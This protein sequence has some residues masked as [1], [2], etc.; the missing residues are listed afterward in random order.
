MRNTTS[1]GTCFM[2]YCWHA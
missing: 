1:G 2:A